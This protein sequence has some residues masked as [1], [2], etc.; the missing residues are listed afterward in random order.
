MVITIFLDHMLNSKW[1]IKKNKLIENISLE[2]I[3]ERFSDVTLC[4][5]YILIKNLIDK[6]RLRMT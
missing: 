2:L 5:H 1:L 4:L 6:K 3:V